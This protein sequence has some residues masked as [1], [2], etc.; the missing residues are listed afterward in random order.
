MHGFPDRRVALSFEW[1]AKRRRGAVSTRLGQHRRLD[2]YLAT[3]AHPKFRALALTVCVRNEA[4]IP[5]IQAAYPWTVV[6]A[7]YRDSL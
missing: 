7:I 4:L 6:Q 1:H 5:A 2:T 3:V